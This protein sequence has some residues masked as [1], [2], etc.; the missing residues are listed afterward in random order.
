[1]TATL[2]VLF[3]CPTCNGVAESPIARLEC[4][5][6][7]ATPHLATVMDEVDDCPA[8]TPDLRVGRSRIRTRLVV[9][10]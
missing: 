7:P 2:A 8:L 5:G 4:F 6:T 9:A 3:R 10:R 1:M